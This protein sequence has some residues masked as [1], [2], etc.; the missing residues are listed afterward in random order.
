LEATSG[1]QWQQELVNDVFL[2]TM[3]QI[4]YTLSDGTTGVMNFVSAP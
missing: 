3:G 1:Y 4:F 2:V